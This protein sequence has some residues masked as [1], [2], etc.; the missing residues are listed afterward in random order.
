MDGTKRTLE[1]GRGRAPRPPLW[2]LTR[3]RCGRTEVLA[4]ELVAGSRALPVFSFAEEARLF[5][6]LGAC[7]G[8]GW[9]GEEIEAEDLA[10]LLLGPL[11]GISS[12]ALDPLP[13]F[14]IEPANRLLCLGRGSFLDLLL[15]DG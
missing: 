10:F 5:V 1:P 14:G 13:G 8:A 7:E 2:L 12:V 9:H 15:P 4:A 6:G 11:G 3:R